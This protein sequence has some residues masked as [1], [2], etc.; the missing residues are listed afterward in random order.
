MLTKK[1]QQNVKDNTARNAELQKIKNKKSS[2][3][4]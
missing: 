4:N 1:E 2:R 3:R